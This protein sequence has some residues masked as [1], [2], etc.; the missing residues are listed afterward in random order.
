MGAMK[1][2]FMAHEDLLEQAAIFAEARPRLTLESANM[3]QLLKAAS[4]M[5]CDLRPVGAE[6]YGIERSI[7]ALVAR[8]EARS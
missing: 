3:L 5:I 1:R 6:P 4:N 2:A 7:D 8:V